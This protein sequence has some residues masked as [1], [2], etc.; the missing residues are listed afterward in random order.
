MSHVHRQNSAGLRAVDFFCGAGG[1]SYGLA[2]A[3]IEVLAGIDID[4]SCRATYE[5]NNRPV[6]A[7]PPIAPQ[8]SA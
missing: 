6:F 7:A 3:G 5:F 4:A 8:R 2:L 1:M